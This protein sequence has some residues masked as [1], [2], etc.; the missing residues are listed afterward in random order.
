MQNPNGPYP[1]R[2]VFLGRTP[3][4][5]PAFAYLVTGRSPASRERRAVPRDNGVIMGPID[6]TPYDWLRHYTAVKYDNAIGFLAVS[7]GIQT[8]ALYETYRLLYHCG[9]RAS[10]GCFRKIMDGANYEPDSLKTPRIAGLVITPPGKNRPEPV[11]LMGIK[12]A[13][14]PAYVW[15][16]TFD[17][18]ALA[19]VSTYTGEMA[20]PKP[21]GADSGPSALV[22]DAE[23]PR[24]LAHF[25]YDVSAAEN[26][27]Q[28]IRVA[29]VAG[30]RQ[31]DGLTWSLFHLNR[32]GD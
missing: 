3:A 19:G 30:V 15:E 27:G 8:E 11:Y 21:F 6:N 26:N 4:G 5:R 25:I 31:D 16:I 24:D 22:C 14:V 29:A 10:R 2:Q 23:T 20:D 32:H 7:N 9:A 28:D 12:T 17:P 13:G 18:G 1:G